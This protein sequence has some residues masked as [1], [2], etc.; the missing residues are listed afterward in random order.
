M[1]FNEKYEV[2]QD[3]LKSFESILEDDFELEYSVGL[4]SQ[5]GSAINVFS[6]G[7]DDTLYKICYISG[8][9]GRDIN[10]DEMNISASAVVLNNSD[11]S[12]WLIPYEELKKIDILPKLIDVMGVDSYKDTD[13]DMIYRFP[14][15]TE[16]T[17]K[18]TS[19]IRRLDEPIVISAIENIRSGVVNKWLLETKDNK[20]LYMRERSGSIQVYDGLTRDDETIFHAFI[21]REH[22]GTY[23]KDE[24]I[25]DIVFAV[26]YIKRSNNMDRT[27]SQEI[28]DEYHGSRELSFNND[29]D[30]RGVETEGIDPSFD[31]EDE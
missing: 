16:I 22:P 11:N 7:D 12:A 25:L 18:S 29:Y 21:G 2:S 15:G 19:P 6:F 28:L 24:E 4:T 17:A 3:E 26:D 1:L 31:F 13:I 5:A 14:D 27:V 8:S 23:L 30:T 9:Y 20:Q 10:G